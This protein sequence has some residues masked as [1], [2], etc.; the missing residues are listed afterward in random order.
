VLGIFFALGYA[1]L[2][3]ILPPLYALGIRD[4]SP[5]LANAFRISVGGLFS[6]ALA[7]LTEDFVGQ[8]PFDSVQMGFL[9]A[10][11]F[12]GMGLGDWLYLKCL[13]S[14]EVSFIIGIANVHPLFAALL[15]FLFRTEALAATTL[16]ASI[17]IVIG[18]ILVHTTQNVD[19]EQLPR[20]LVHNPELRSQGYRKCTV[21]AVLAAFTWGVTRFGLGLS[22]QYFTPFSANAIRLSAIAILLFLVVSLQSSEKKSKNL[23]KSSL[24][25]F[26]VGGILGVG[27]GMWMMLVSIELLGVTKSTAISSIS[28]FFSALMAIIIL[29]EKPSRIRLGGILLVCLGVLLISVS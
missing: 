26:G 22:L 17:I 20:H 27:I 14:A 15:T 10:I 1:I 24:I 8:L 2:G 29:K 23:S 9:I 28:P 13:K 3:A 25:I 6:F 4:S 16:V 12:V 5:L 19:E 7:I 11:T 18:V 21:F